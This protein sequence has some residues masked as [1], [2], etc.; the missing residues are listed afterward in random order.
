M[1]QNSRES[2]LFSKTNVLQSF[3]CYIQVPWEDIKQRLDGTVALYMEY[4]SVFVTVD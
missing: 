1:T 2:R 3:N 4:S